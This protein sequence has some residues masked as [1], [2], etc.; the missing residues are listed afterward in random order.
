MRREE[1]FM[2]ILGGLDEKYVSMAMPRSCGHST[3]GDTGNVIEIKPVEVSPEV[4]RKDLRIYWITRTLGMAAAAVLIVGAAVLLIMNWDKIAVR[5]PDT[6]SVVTTDNTTMTEPSIIITDSTT[7]DE[8][9]ATPDT[10]N[11][12]SFTAADEWEKEQR[13]QAFYYPYFAI[14][15]IPD[16][17]I[18]LADPNELEKWELMSVDITTTPPESITDYANICTFIAHFGISPENAKKALGDEYREYIGRMWQNSEEADRVIDIICSGD[19]DDNGTVGELI[20]NTTWGFGGKLICPNWLYVHSLDEWKAAGVKAATVST[21]Y[22]YYI[23]NDVLNEEQTAEFKAK[24]DQYI[25]ENKQGE[26][27][28]YVYDEDGDV[29]PVDA[30]DTTAPAEEQP[31][32]DELKALVQQGAEACGLKITVNKL[33]RA[34]LNLHYVRDRSVRYAEMLAY[35]ISDRY[36]IQVQ[37]GDT[38]QTYDPVNLQRWNDEE[39]WFD[40]LL[41]IGGEE[42]GDEEDDLILFYGS[43]M[44]E[45]EIPNG[46][47]RIAKT[48]GVKSEITGAFLG[49]LTAY[50]EF[51]IDALTQNLFDIA[52]SLENV[53]PEGATWIVW[54]DG[55]DYFYVKRNLGYYLSYIIERMNTKGEW[56]EVQHNPNDFA[57]DIEPLNE[58]GVTNIAI[59]WKRVYGSLPDGTYR[60]SKPFVNYAYD[61]TGKAQILNCCNYYSV[62]FVIGEGKPDWGIKLSVKGD[63]TA[64]GLTLVISQRGGTYTGELEYGE[65]YSIERKNGDKW[66]PLEYFDGAVWHDLAYFVEPNTDKEE[67]LDWR[68]L[69]GTLPAGTYRIAK[70]FMDFRGSGD[71]DKQTFY[72]PFKITDDMASKLGIALRALK[73]NARTMTLQIVQTGDTGYEKI[74]TNPYRYTIERKTDGIWQ[75]YY[76]PQ[77]GVPTPDLGLKVKNSGVTEYQF[78]WSEA[79]GSLPVGDYRLGM[80]FSCGDITETRYCEFTIEEGMTNEFGIAVRALEISRTGGKFAIESVSGSIDGLA[81]YTNDF[82][83]QKQTGSGKWKDVEKLHTDGNTDIRVSHIGLHTGAGY[84]G[85]TEEV[86]WLTLYGKLAN[87]H[88][89]IVKTFREDVDGDARQIDVC[90][91]FDINAD[92]PETLSD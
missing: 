83:I 35:G 61:S 85:Q 33:T 15:T 18:A 76:A 14:N 43:N 13:R 87:G 22:D 42:Y 9:P 66:E 19:L 41:G 80:T 92:T 70:E 6:P 39:M 11:F 89:R 73:Y 72:V 75:S 88:Y 49:Q 55:H 16:N 52:T 91:E 65:P 25:A 48:V 27:S 12:S 78:D 30:A 59:N 29:I 32:D 81:T 26:V 67:K 31:S 54:Q 3:V 4:S 79:A 24:I 56:E 77:A 71:Y 53:T 34:S 20:N 47:Y 51:T 46:H 64:E 82:R 57:P 90:G 37:K 21:M 38:W 68:W 7:A 60:L 74:G 40:S 62:E 2:D 36:E 28:E 23:N 58:N 45:S 17:L 10:D 69:Y 63:V 1:L 5:G 84:I 50:A 86:D 44:Y 8:D